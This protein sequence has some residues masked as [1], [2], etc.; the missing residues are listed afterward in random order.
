M[1]IEQGNTFTEE[2][3]NSVKVGMPI[4]EVVR[5]M[6]EPVLID[7][8]TDDRLNYVYTYEPGYQPICIKRVTFI[9]YHGRVSKI[10]RF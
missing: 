1:D 3:V 6:G 7:A 5:I 8:F 4:D 2:Q 10:V 9:I